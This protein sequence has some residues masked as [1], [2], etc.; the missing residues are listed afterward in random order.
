MNQTSFPFIQQ[1][2]EIRPSFQ[3]A[4]H[5]IRIHEEYFHTEHLLEEQELSCRENEIH[6]VTPLASSFFRDTIWFLRDLSHY[7]WEYHRLKKEQDLFVQPV[8]LCPKKPVHPVRLVFPLV[9]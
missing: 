5:T 6:R 9:S 4:H 3:E 1:Q 2:E 8:R 7:K